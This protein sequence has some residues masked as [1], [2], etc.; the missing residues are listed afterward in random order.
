MGQSCS[1]CECGEEDFYIVETKTGDIKGMGSLSTVYITLV[2]TLN[3]CSEFTALN[4][5][6]L[7]AF[8]KGSWDR[9][10]ITPKFTFLPI[11]K[12]IIGRRDDDVSEAWFLEM[13]RICRHPIDT[14]NNVSNPDHN[15]QIFPVQRWVKCNQFISITEGDCFLPQN[16]ENRDQRIYELTYYQSCYRFNHIS[17]IPP[18]CLEIPLDEIHSNYMKWD[19]MQRKIK[20]FNKFSLH[21]MA[22]NESWKN[23]EER[24]KLFSPEGTLKIPSS[25]HPKLDDGYFVFQR[26]GGCYPTAIKLCKEIPKNVS[27]TPQIIE[28]FL[29][30]FTLQEAMEKDHLFCVDHKIMKG[31][32]SVCT[33]ME[34]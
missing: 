4:G 26:L 1:L 14:Q 20:I 19:I 30:G 15:W 8:K 31:I 10:R 17:G 24:L 6:F 18:Q 32:R 7:T 13:V 5:F 11:K 21:E 25:L 29:E 27:I 9:F 34:Y 2:N 28:P 23:D 33:G 16:D 22:T 3:E 12:I